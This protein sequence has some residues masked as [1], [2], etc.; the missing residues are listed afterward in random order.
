VKFG[1][2]PAKC[3]DEEMLIAR[4]D[5]DGIIRLPAARPAQPRAGAGVVI[6]DGP[7][8]GFSGLYAGMSAQ[9]PELVLINL[10]GRQIP[11]E[12]LRRP[13][14]STISEEISR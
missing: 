5:P 13:G 6:A 7:F 2:A 9:E 1:A 14:R 10:L 8:R 4:A 3:P 12:I 11:V